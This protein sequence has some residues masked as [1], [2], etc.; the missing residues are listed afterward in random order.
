MYADVDS[1]AIKQVR[2]H[3]DVRR[4]KV[5]HPLTG[6]IRHDKKNNVSNRLQDITSYIKTT[7]CSEIIHQTATTRMQ[8]VR[9]V[10]GFLCV[11]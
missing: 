1:A 11:E 2:N 10:N 5:S 7:Q 8:S 4:M 6:N 3:E 9:Q